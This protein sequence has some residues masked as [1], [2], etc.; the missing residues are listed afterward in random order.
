MKYLSS[1]PQPQPSGKAGS[2]SSVLSNDTES[3]PSRMRFE[4]W[5]DQ[6]QKH[7]ERSVYK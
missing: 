4:T 6:Q 7:L 2:M 5:K 3:V 1:A